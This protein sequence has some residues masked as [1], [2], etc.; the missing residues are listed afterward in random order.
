MAYQYIFYGS[1]LGIG[2]FAFMG[3]TISSLLC[4]IVL[5]ANELL[6]LRLKLFVER[7]RRERLAETMTKEVSKFLDE[8]FSKG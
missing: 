6:L 4:V 8:I 2:Y 3:N 5:M 7:L 1:F